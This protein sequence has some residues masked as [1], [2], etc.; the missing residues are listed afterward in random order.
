MHDIIA[1]KIMEIN[2]YQ[3]NKSNFEVIVDKVTEALPATMHT[4]HIFRN[5]KTISEN[6][7]II[8]SNQQKYNLS[9]YKVLPLIGGYYKH[10]L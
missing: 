5:G 8:F 1:Q 7:K 6:L 10:R 3:N 2:G 9:I 4:G